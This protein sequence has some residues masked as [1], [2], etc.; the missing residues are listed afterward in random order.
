MMVTL[1]NIEKLWFPCAIIGMEILF[2]ILFGV[3]VEY[4][5]NAAPITDTSGSVAESDAEI[6][7]LYPR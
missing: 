2:L 7:Q 5:D 3:F 6:Q 1:S 4:D